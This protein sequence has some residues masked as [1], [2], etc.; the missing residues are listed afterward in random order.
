MLSFS[1]FI[2]RDHNFSKQRNNI[3]NLI[4][5][6]ELLQL[7]N[8]QKSPII[9]VTKHSFY[10]YLFTQRDEDISFKLEKLRV[11]LI[12]ESENMV[13][14]IKRI[15]KKI[16]ESKRLAWIMILAL[17]NQKIGRPVVKMLYEKD[18]DMDQPILRIKAL[19]TYAFL[20]AHLYYDVPLKN[21][22]L[23]QTWCGYSTGI[24][25]QNKQKTDLESVMSTSQFKFLTNLKLIYNGDC[26]DLDL[27]ES[28][29]AFKDIYNEKPLFPVDFL[30]MRA[31]YDTITEI[32]VDNTKMIRSSHFCYLLQSDTKMTLELLRYNINVYQ[33]YHGIT[34]L[35]IAARYGN[36]DLV[37]VYCELGFGTND[38]DI[39]GNTPLH[40]AAINSHTHCFN[41][42]I[43]ISHLNVQRYDFD[44][45]LTNIKNHSGLMPT[46][47]KIKENDDNYKIDVNFIISLLKEARNEA[48]KK[49]KFKI[50][51]SNMI[52]S[53]ESYGLFK[54]I[55]KKLDCLKETPMLL[56]EEITS[57]INIMQII[58]G[59]SRTIVKKEDECEALREFFK[60]Y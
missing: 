16:K 31:K 51:R 22:S 28:E 33:N 36:L 59:R 3:L 8:V 32:L 26:D 18:F 5:H 10:S 58:H 30:M 4:S 2:R 42:L 23:G 54:E 41:Y 46:D 11:S 21:Y 12:D 13:F 27:I 47:Y 39:M 55:E 19:P 6:T 56:Y 9:K 37:I 49:F 45:A 38:Q 14:S 52:N 24:M 29:N 53:S 15:N 44:P 34:P 20:Y 17:A 48:V 40:Y 60:F 7:I 57:Y 1:E 50:I 43:K 25:Y 35:H